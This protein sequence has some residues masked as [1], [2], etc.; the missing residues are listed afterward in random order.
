M[1]TS[2]PAMPHRAMQLF[3]RGCLCPGCVSS[4]LPCSILLQGAPGSG[5]TALAALIARDSEFP[6]YK[7][8]TPKDLTARAFGEA[9]KVAPRAC[10]ASSLLRICGGE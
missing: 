2:A 10:R 4:C 8:I 9:G 1:M 7:I 6:S 3:F 5:K